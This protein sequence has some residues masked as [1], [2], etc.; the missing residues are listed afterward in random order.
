MLASMGNL[1]SRLGAA[2]LTLV[3]MLTVAGCSANAPEPAEADKPSPT[4]TMSIEPAFKASC[5]EFEA[6]SERTADVIV[7][8]WN[9]DDTGTADAELEALPAAYDMLALRTDGQ[10]GERMQAAADVVLDQPLMVMSLDPDEYFDAIRAVQRAC[11]V[12]G[13][14]IGVATWN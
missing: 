5:E 1:S 13:T 9:G 11:E 2:T 6:L 3:C 7:E 10:V 4:P 8:V 14:S 12:E